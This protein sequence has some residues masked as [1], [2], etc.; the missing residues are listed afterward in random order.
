MIVTKTSKKVGLIDG[1]FYPC[2]K[3]PNCVS[4]QSPDELHKIEPIT[5]D[6]PLE[7][8]KGK[9]VEI[10]ISMKRT[11]MITCMNNNIHADFIHEYLN[12]WIM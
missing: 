1:K 7:K 8:A 6:S 12:L 10:I 2:P 3:T 5:Y 4:T 9:L 11:K